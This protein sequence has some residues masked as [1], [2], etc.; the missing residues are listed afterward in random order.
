MLLTCDNCQTIFRIEAG[1]IGEKGRQVRCSVCHHSWHATATPQKQ[2]IT[3]DADMLSDSVRALRLPLGVMLAVILVL[4][5]L[6][7][8]RQT[9]SAYNPSLIGIYDM[10]GLSIT[11]DP[12]QLEVR[13]LKA[14]Y[15]GDVL[16]LQGVLANVSGWRAHAAPLEVQLFDQEGQ[17]VRKSQILPD[18]RFIN[19]SGETRFFA[20]VADI[21]RDQLD[22][23]VRPLAIRLDAFKY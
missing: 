17:L 3:E 10:V 15:Q 2:A 16:R 9:L 23:T 11:P 18:E 13:D 6:I 20:Q 4:S 12:A 7:L 5:S 1:A 14:N 22:I 8:A 19:A 21:E